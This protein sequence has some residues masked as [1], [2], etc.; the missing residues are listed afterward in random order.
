MINVD[1]FNLYTKGT[2]SGSLECP[3]Y[4]GLTVQIKKNNTK[5]NNNINSTTV[6]V[7]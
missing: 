4:T 5:K 1:N 7:V 3:L 2:F 6:N